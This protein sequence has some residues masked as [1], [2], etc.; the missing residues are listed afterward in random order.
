MARIRSSA[1]PKLW[2]QLTR[3]K[4]NETATSYNRAYATAAYEELSS[5][6][7]IKDLDLICKT[8]LRQL[9]K[10]QKVST[11]EDECDGDNDD[12]DISSKSDHSESDHHSESNHDDFESDHDEENNK[13][14]EDSEIILNK[15]NFKAVLGRKTL[16]LL[17]IASKDEN[18]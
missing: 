17:Q 13:N 14:D 1:M 6:G 16:S 5:D 4:D 9:P 18:F 3:D 15:F 2:T 11:V 8:C 12:D 10:L 7:L